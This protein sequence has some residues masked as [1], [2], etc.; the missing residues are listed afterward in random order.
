MLCKIN[1]NRFLFL[2]LTFMTLFNNC[3]FE[4][5]GKRNYLQLTDI[6]KKIMGHCVSM[7]NYKYSKKYNPMDAHGIEH[8]GCCDWFYVAFHDP[9]DNNCDGNGDVWYLI[10]SNASDDDDREYIIDNNDK[11]IAIDE[12]ED[13]IHCH[14]FDVISCHDYY[15]NQ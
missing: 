12:D 2:F 8:D 7:I 5:F 14:T 10:N 6:S 9:S 1:D 13:Y 3:T 11:G 15:R 4:D